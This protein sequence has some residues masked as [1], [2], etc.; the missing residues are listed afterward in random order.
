MLLTSVAILA[1]MHSPV[2]GLRQI[3][4]REV[5]YHEGQTLCVGYEAFPAK[6]NGKV[7]VVLVVHDWNGIDEYEQR[8]CRELASLGYYAFAIDVYG[9]YRPKTAAENGAEAGKYYKDP[10]L[11]LRRLKAGYDTAVQT[12]SAEVNT[13]KVA[14]IGYCFGGKAV[15]EMA[16]AGFNLKSIVSFHG[17]LATTTPAEPGKVKGRIL[18]CHGAEDPFVPTKDVDAFKAEMSI[19][20]VTYKF[21][22]YPGAVH[23][24]TV[25]SNAPKSSGAAYNASADKQSWEEMNKWFRATL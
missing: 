15:L 19:A 8:R 6:S 4:A 1:L 2:G 23:A 17:A 11:F 10:A 13:A 7:P 5:R 21:V 20:K 24:F 22:A 16:R 25:P 9:G 18:V 12:K 14:A 3:E